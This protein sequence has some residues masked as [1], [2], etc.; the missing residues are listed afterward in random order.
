MKV[1]FCIL[2]GEREDNPARTRW[3]DP[4]PVDPDGRPYQHRWGN[5]EDVLDPSDSEAT[6]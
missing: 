6:R 2:C 3:C 4:D 1:R 5:P